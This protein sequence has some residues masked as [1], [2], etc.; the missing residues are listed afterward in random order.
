VSIKVGERVLLPAVR[1]A[2]EDTLIISDGFSCREQIAQT[3]HRHAL[4]LA[5]V[6]QMAIRQENAGNTSSQVPDLSSAPAQSTPKQLVPAALMGS[7]LIGGF[8]IWLLKRKNTS[9]L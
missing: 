2:D 8:F 4:H 3:T 1:Q 9:S 6:L 5:Q 7:V